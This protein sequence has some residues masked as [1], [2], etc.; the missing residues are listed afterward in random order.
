MDDARLQYN[1]SPAALL[2]ADGTPQ[3][4]HIAYDEDGY[5]FCDG[6]P[7]AQNEPQAEQI[8]YAFPALKRLVGRRFPDAYAASDMF[9]YRR[10]GGTGLAPDIF[11]AFGAGARDRHGE[12][13]NSYKLF[14]GEPVPSFVLEVLSGT[15]AD[16]DLGRKRA[17]YAEWGVEEYWMFDPFGKRI[18]TFISAERLSLAGGGFEAIEPL[19]GTAV[20]PSAVLGLELRAEGDMLR[21]RDPET[22]EDLRDYSDEFDA[23]QAAEEQAAAVEERAAEEAVARQAAEERADAEAAGRVDAERRAAAEAMAR[24]ALEAELAELRRQRRNEGP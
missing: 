18:P 19:P 3:L 9:V 12:K 16:R 17:A 5:P 15:T 11:V 21:I 20:Y 6:E 24:K 1:G 4:P 2:A 7:L 13:R 23:R 22:G 10:R 8:F 14:E